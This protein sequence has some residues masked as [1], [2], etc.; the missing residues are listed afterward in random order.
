M[1]K[2]HRKVFYLLLG[3]LTFIFAFNFGVENSQVGV[4]AIFIGSC[5]TTTDGL[6]LCP[7]DRPTYESDTT[8]P[9]V[10]S[11]G[12]SSSWTRDNVTIRITASDNVS[13]AAFPY[14]FTTSN[15]S[16]SCS[17]QSSN[18]MTF[19]ENTN[20]TYYTFAKDSSGNIGSGGSQ[21]VKIDKGTPVVTSSIS[22]T[23]WTKGSVTLSISATSYSEIARYCI[24]TSTSTSGCSWKTS[25]FSMTVSTSGEKTYYF[26]AK[27]NAGKVGS[28]A[29]TV[30]IDK[31]S[32]TISNFEGGS[33]S[34]Q[35]SSVT[36]KITASDSLSGVAYY[37][38][39]TSS[40]SSSCSWQKSS[41]KTIYSDTNA[42]YYA[43]AKDAVGNVSSSK[44]ATVKI[45]TT[46]PKITCDG[47]SV[48]TYA[49]ACLLSA[50]DYG[51]GMSYF[52]ISPTPSIYGSLLFDNNVGGENY[53]YGNIVATSTSTT[54]TIQVY[55]VAG[56]GA[57]ASVTIYNSS[58]KITCKIGEESDT[59]STIY[60][61]SSCS[62]SFSDTKQ[63]SSYSI[64]GPESVSTT[65]IL[66][67]SYSYGTLSKEGKY[68]IKVTNAAGNT[69]TTTLYIDKTDPYMPNPLYPTS[70]KLL[71]GSV[72]IFKA[73]SMTFKF[74]DDLSGYSYANHDFY[75]AS[76]DAIY[77]TTNSSITLY[78]GYTYKITVY[79][80]AGNSSKYEIEFDTTAPEITCGSKT[81]SSTTTISNS[82]TAYFTDAN[83]SRYDIQKG[84]KDFTSGTA[85]SYTF[86]S[87]G[88]YTITAY[89][90]VGN[91]STGKIY[92]DDTAPS[93]RTGTTY[94]KTNPETNW[95]SGSSKSFT[96][97]DGGSGF[98]YATYDVET[99][100]GALSTIKT[101]S[102]TLNASTLTYI[103]TVYDKAGNNSKY[104]IVVDNTAPTITSSNC[105]IKN[106]VGGE[107]YT[108][109]KHCTLNFSDDTKFYRYSVNNVYHTE[110]SLEMNT[111]A[112]Y[113]ICA[114]DMAG[115]EIQ[116]TIIMDTTNP[117]WT[118]ANN[119][120][121]TTGTSISFT[122]TD[123]I[124]ISS[125]FLSDFG[126][127]WSTSDKWE[128]TIKSSNYT[129]D[130]TKKLTFTTTAPNV[131]S[132]TVYYLWITPRGED[133]A[134]NEAVYSGKM[135]EI[136]NNS[137][138][139]RYTILPEVVED[140]EAPKILCGNSVPTSGVSMS[141]CNLTF[142]DN[143]NLAS[144]KIYDANNKLLSS[145]TIS[146]S[147]HIVGYLEEIY[148]SSEYKIVVTDAAGNTTTIDNILIDI[149]APELKM[150]GSSLTQ[151]KGYFV[152]SSVT[153]TTTE[154]AVITV[155]GKKFSTDSNKYT[156]DI[157]SYDLYYETPNYITLTGKS[158]KSLL[159]SAGN[160]DLSKYGY[161]IRIDL[162]DEVGNTST[163]YFNVCD[164]VLSPVTVNGTAYTSNAS[165]SVYGDFT[166][167]FDE[168]VQV[169]GIG[170]TS[171]KSYFA[172]KEANKDG[173]KVS[174][175]DVFGNTL[176]VI[177]TSRSVDLTESDLY[178]LID[179]KKYVPVNNGVYYS[180]TSITPVKSNSDLTYSSSNVGTGLTRYTATL[181][182]KTTTFYVYVASTAMMPIKYG[183][184][185]LEYKGNYSLSSGS[186]I[187]TGLSIDAPQFYEW[188]GSYGNCST[189]VTSSG[190]YTLTLHYTNDVEVS[191]Y[192]NI[193]ITT[194]GTTNST[195]SDT[196]GPE[197]IV[198]KETNKGEVSGY[199]WYAFSK[200]DEKIKVS[201]TDTSG[202]GSVKY[203]TKN[204]NVS[205]FAGEGISINSLPFEITFDNQN[206]ILIYKIEAKD[207]FGNSSTKEFVVISKK[208]GIA[209]SSYS[210]N[211]NIKRTEEGK[212]SF[213]QKVS[214]NYS[215][216][217][218]EKIGGYSLAN[219][220]YSFNIN[221]KGEK[222][223][224]KD[225]SEYIVD[226]KY[227]LFG[228][229]ID[230]NFAETIEYNIIENSSTNTMD[231]LEACVELA[232][233]LE[234]EDL[235]KEGYANNSSGTPLYSINYSTKKIV[236]LSGKV[237]NQTYP[238]SITLNFETFFKDYIDEN[239]LDDIKKSYTFGY[240][241]ASPYFTSVKKATEGLIN[242]AINL[243]NN[244]NPTMKIYNANY[245]MAIFQI[246]CDEGRNQGLPISLIISSENASTTTTTEVVNSGIVTLDM[247]SSNEKKKY[248]I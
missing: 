7:T 132:S 195:T 145:E 246:Y 119:Y 93:M 206:E 230:I 28:D 32:P 136:K 163:Y 238:S 197:I 106:L 74:E 168:N 240:I 224:I 16:S 150:N 148:S 210:D 65:S 70:V 157:N 140:K 208:S 130:G 6:T 190:K 91:Y 47:N 182:G 149:T 13:L 200:E 86:T 45:D 3:I 35:K 187:T 49:S 33:S 85:A 48:P 95:L 155:Y 229:S 115:N 41:S 72:N 218:I 139:Y 245:K 117:V 152:N 225:S 54:Y 126:Y 29:Q 88:D 122:L 36:L 46:A 96:F 194:S 243:E 22:T 241:T 184:T 181:A 162:G 99:A 226:F 55:D 42:T 5:A 90:T 196:T 242:N 236:T 116:V 202:M 84:G 67:K 94:L 212:Y 201:I 103:I 133:I 217:K 78:S 44:S 63:L 141:S 111:D 158:I 107:T 62:L 179:N 128:P 81:L 89:D 98:A 114:F 108:F 221:K 247:L 235:V 215:N 2:E 120:S 110:N 125:D 244:N 214:S 180:S 109:S 234:Y 175:N 204:D 14:C 205:S 137:I 43:F 66:K 79:D 166:M 164:F 248:L 40:S 146:G 174:Y 61:N 211:D 228:N 71:T 77:D 237:I 167:T 156:F 1:R 20:K 222:I 64:F 68:T 113:R 58:P 153:L 105:A 25:A 154:S 30:K 8:A 177:V 38:F 15:S 209:L 129:K 21:T 34:W 185:S 186:V 169:K 37:C 102:Y 232:T 192:V 60:T 159:E 231:Y 134:G 191:D 135:F 198:E 17:W 219:D 23:S 131:Y 160:Y 165:L 31:T 203:W 97:V 188:N 178:L 127:A 80:K 112:T 173:G 220:A 24:T 216:V 19:S 199:E 51:S 39:N 170:E 183:S 9:T 10:S 56:N 26:F 138:V 176:E 207:Y 18:T 73:S 171:F 57:S 50:S 142:T 118:T 11:S 92:I 100:M 239:I 213:T 189:T 223:N 27:S 53:V 227:S 143:I 101:T 161:A 75:G 83:F 69:S 172:R 59:S 121:I 4:K 52:N 123:N 151:N 104:R 147:S 76:Q 124:S 193:S 87:D 12:G 82:C 144:Y 233:G